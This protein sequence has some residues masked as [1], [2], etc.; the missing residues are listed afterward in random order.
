MIHW[1]N[2][3]PTPFDYFDGWMD[4]NLSAPVGKPAGS[5]Y[6][7]YNNPPAQAA[8]AQYDGSNDTATSSRRSTSWRTS[9][10]RR[11]R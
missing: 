2:Q 11:P 9:C 5:D 7:R 4:N 1:G 10:P 8:L 6:G 3:G